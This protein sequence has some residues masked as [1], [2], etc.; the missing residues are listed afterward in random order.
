MRMSEESG[1]TP[2]G[3]LGR[4][5]GMAE[6]LSSSVQAVSA[7]DR[8]QAWQLGLAQAEAARL[9]AAEDPRLTASKPVGVALSLKF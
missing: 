4:L 8:G 9:G 1:G 2:S 5:K 3:L 6:S 7:V